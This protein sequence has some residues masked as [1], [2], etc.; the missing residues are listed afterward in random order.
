MS[1]LGS[2][3]IVA[4]RKHCNTRKLPSFFGF[5]SLL[6]KRGKKKKEKINIPP[7]FMNLMSLFQERSISGKNL[8]SH[9]KGLG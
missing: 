2:P 3:E 9:A 6:Y 5:V 1:G 8:L 7:A 4:V